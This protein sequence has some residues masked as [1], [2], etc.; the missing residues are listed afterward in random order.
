M[1]DA[2][3]RYTSALCV[4]YQA[5]SVVAYGLLDGK[6]TVHG[7][8]PSAATLLR[9]LQISLTLICSSVQSVSIN[10]SYNSYM[11]FQKCMDWAAYSGGD[12]VDMVHILSID[13]QI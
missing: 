2:E 4:G 7:S 10:T 8:N 1:H 11:S 6:Q 3:Y 13:L 9:T 12:L 5:M